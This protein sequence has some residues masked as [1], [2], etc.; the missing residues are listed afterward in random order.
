MMVRT[1][2]YNLI[3]QQIALLEYLENSSKDIVH[4]DKIKIAAQLVRLEHYI[5]ECEQLSPALE[6][7]I[8]ITYKNSQ[9]N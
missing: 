2:K 9:L 1:H 6:I 7:K 8:G 5:N 4:S 3:D